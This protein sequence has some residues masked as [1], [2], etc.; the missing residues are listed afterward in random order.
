MFEVRLP[1]HHSEI[2]KLTEQQAM[3]LT[4]QHD[5]FDSVVGATPILAHQLIINQ[6]SLSADLHLTVESDK[7]KKKTVADRRRRSRADSGAVS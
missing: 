5:D 1:M 6:D 4:H 7:K 3:L 2:S